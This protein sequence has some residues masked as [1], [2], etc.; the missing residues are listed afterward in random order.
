[1]ADEINQE[2]PRFA[3]EKVTEALNR[4]RKSVNGSKILVLGVGYKKDSGDVRESPALDIMK[5]LRERGAEISYHGPHGPLIVFGN[6]PLGSVP[7]T[8]RSLSS[9]DAVVVA[10][11]HS[12]FNAK[13][14]VDHSRLIID[15]RNLSDGMDSGKIVRL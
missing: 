4:E 1:M 11:D 13:E 5:L 9:A 3:V 6:Q 7:L 12:V 2:M 8:G 10:T 14:I 15:T